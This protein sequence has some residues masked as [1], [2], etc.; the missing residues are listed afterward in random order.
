MS[1]SPNDKQDRQLN[2]PS[3][4]GA[5][6][7]ML[8]E[9]RSFSGHERNCCFLSTLSSLKAGRRF[10]NISAI[11]GID[12]PDDGRALAQVDWD[13]DGDLDLWVSNRNAP[14]VRFLR[15]DV[16]HSGH[17]LALRLVGNGK[18]TNRDAIGA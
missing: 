1:Q 7:A 15:N 6:S 13:H 5:L 17:F 11:S 12:F 9:G 14:R 18:T 10:A 16:P 4:F 8:R 2:L 3:T